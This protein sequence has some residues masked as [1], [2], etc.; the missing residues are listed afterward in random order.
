MKIVHDPLYQTPEVAYVNAGVCVRAAG[1]NIAP[2]AIFA[3]ADHRPKMPEAMLQLGELL[4]ERGDTTEARQTVQL[5]LAVNE[6]PRIFS[7]WVCVPSARP[8]TTHG[9][10]LRTT[11]ATGI[12]DV[13]AGAH[14]AVRPDSM[15]EAAKHRARACGPS[16]NAGA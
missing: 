12:P 14:A 2:S 13:R 3:G 10:L 8:A 16:A 4:L 11:A 7:G 5:Y 9:R 6:S 1:N 15:S